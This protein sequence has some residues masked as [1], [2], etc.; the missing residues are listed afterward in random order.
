MFEEGRPNRDRSFDNFIPEYKRVERDLGIRDSSVSDPYAPPSSKHEIEKL[1]H[2]Y[3]EE[4][5]RF[6]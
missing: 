2:E 1:I 6:A 5:K 3:K 4:N